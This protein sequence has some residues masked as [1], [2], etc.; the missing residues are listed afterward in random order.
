MPVFTY[1]KLYKAQQGR[2]FYCNTRMTMLPAT[3]DPN[4]IGYTRD[5]FLPWVNGHTLAN[6]VVMACKACNNHKGHAI[7]CR[8][9]VQKFVKLY[10]NKRLAYSPVP[11]IQDWLETEQFLNIIEKWCGNLVVG[12][13]I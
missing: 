12:V 10:S 8:R 1:A 3:N 7:P 11:Q 13:V 9:L 2:C 6:N 5:H 4:D